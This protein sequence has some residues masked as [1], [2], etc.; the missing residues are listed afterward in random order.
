MK[1]L[2]SFISVSHWKAFRKIAKKKKNSL[3]FSHK[4]Q[5]QQYIYDHRYAKSGFIILNRFE[6]NGEGKKTRKGK[7]SICIKINKETCYTF[8]PPFI[9]LLNIFVGGKRTVILIFYS[10]YVKTHLV[11]FIQSPLYVLLVSVLHKL[12]NWQWKNVL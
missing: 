6:Y 9:F 12:Y 10:F 1:S 7:K 3:T 11:I 2:S 5:P 4:H 8:S